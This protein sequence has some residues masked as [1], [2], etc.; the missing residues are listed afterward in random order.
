MSKSESQT[1]RGML[2]N[3]YLPNILPE[4]VAEVQRE[5]FCA[6]RREIIGCCIDFKKYPDSVKIKLKNPVFINPSTQ[7]VAL[8]TTHFW[9]TLPP[10]NETVREWTLSQSMNVDEL[11][12]ILHAL[13]KAFKH[14]TFEVTKL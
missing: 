5:T 11:L 10:D 7:I 4:T 6:I 3:S 1:L 14:Q 9:Y 8:N 2:Y 12:R 13:E